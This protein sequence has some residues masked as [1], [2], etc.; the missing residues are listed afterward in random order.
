MLPENCVEVGSRSEWRAWLAQNH[1]TNSGVWVVW[2]KQSSGVAGT[3]YV[4]LVEEA[5]CFGWVDSKPGKVDELRT[6]LWFSPRKTGSKWAATN[7][8]RVERLMKQGLMHPAGIAK[9]EAAK[10]DGTWDALSVVDA[11]EIPPDLAAAFRKHSGSRKNFLAF[12]PS[13]KKGILEWILNAKKP[14]TRAAR[15]KETAELAAKNVRANQW[16]DKQK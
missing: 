1:T 6:R 2:Y 16:R 15:I 4:E 9:V 10:V 14:E 11:M 13:V 8:E 12:P 3:S 5:L 7:K